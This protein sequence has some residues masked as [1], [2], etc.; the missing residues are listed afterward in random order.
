[1]LMP[2]PKQVLVEEPST[3]KPSLHVIVAVVPWSKELA[4]PVLYVII[5][6]TTLESAVQ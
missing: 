4:G 3:K 5:P 2:S 1:M 6:L